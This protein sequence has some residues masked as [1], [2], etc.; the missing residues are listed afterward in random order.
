MEKVES[1]PR[2]YEDLNSFPEIVGETFERR[3]VRWD[4]HCQTA[5]RMA[6][7]LEEK[8][9]RDL[10]HQKEQAE[11]HRAGEMLDEE[12]KGWAA[13]KEGNLEALLCSLHYVLWPECGWV[14]VSPADLSSAAAI[15]KAYRKATLC[16]HP[17]KVQQKGATVAQKYIAEKIFDLLK[18]ASVKST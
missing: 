9:L 14:R 2:T 3:K 18:E 4:R 11:R 6:K 17:D 5:E 15:R 1:M 16:V 7:A 12:I 10:V 8:K 13:G